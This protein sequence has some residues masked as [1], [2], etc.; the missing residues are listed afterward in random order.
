[1]VFSPV[2]PDSGVMALEQQLRDYL[3]EG[4]RRVVL[5]GVGNMVV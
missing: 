2:I 4:E 5:M 1:M 3:G